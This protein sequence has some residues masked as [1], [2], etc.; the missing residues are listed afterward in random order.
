MARLHSMC[1]STPGAW[2]LLGTWVWAERGQHP[3]LPSGE[4]MSIQTGHGLSSDGWWVLLEGSEDRWG[5]GRQAQM[6]DRPHV[7][8]S[9]RASAEVPSNR[10]PNCTK[11]HRTVSL[12]PREGRR[13][14]RGPAWL[15]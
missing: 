4:G 6:G 1:H 2:C 12:G 11:E 13:S 9:G 14:P 15:S 10:G 7:E 5:D 8:W 3:L